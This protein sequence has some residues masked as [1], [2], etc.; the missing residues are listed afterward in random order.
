MTHPVTKHGKKNTSII[1][2]VIRYYRVSPPA[3]I[4]QWLG[5]VPVVHRHLKL[6]TEK[7]D[8][9]YITQT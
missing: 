4:L 7:L 3:Q 1:L 9:F 6:E 2:E 5:K 8:M